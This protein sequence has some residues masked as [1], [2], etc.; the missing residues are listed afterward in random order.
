MAV[1]GRR[2][3]EKSESR[4]HCTGLMAVGSEKRMLEMLGMRCSEI[5][6]LGAKASGAAIRVLVRC[7]NRIA[8]R[9]EN[10]L[11]RQMWMRVAENGDTG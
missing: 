5:R 10:C 4:R 7:L 9:I 8:R 11:V 2:A 3:L 6:E 1:D